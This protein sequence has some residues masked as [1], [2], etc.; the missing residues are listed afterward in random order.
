M[1]PELNADI[2]RWRQSAIDGT[3]TLA[4]MKLAIAALRGGRISAAIASATSKTKKAPMQ[5]QSADDLL[6]ELGD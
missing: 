1:T 2:A 5:V 3:L 6:S 4:D